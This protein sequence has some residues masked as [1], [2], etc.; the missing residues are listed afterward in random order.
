MSIVLLGAGQLAHALSLVNHKTRCPCIS[1]PK[2]C[3]P[4]VNDDLLRGELRRYLPNVIINAAAY[5][6]VVGAEKAPALAMAVNCDGVA[7]LAEL[8]KQHNALLVHFST[9]YVFGGAGNQPWRESDR[10]APLNIYGKSKLAGEQAILASGCRHLIIRTSWLHSPWRDN[11]LKTMLRLA[12]SREELQVVCDQVGAPTSAMMLAEVAMFAVERVLTKPELAGLYHVAASGAVS[13]YD[14]A[15]C[16]F[17]EA[18]VIGLINKAPQLKP[19]TSVDYGGVVKRP[20]N[21]LLETQHFQQRFGL[22]LPNWREGVT[23]TLQALLEDR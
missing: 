8:A 14:Y 22:L 13:W 10:P 3:Y 15:C 11:F 18:S 7:R 20:L 16:I 23:A 9:D 6:D 21:S 5:T 1:L 12:Q 19:I 17:Q 4:L 2:N